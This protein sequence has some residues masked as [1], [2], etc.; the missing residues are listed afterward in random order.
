MA[1]GQG[2]FLSGKLSK[3]PVAESFILCAI[4]ADEIPII[5]LGGKRFMHYTISHILIL[6]LLL[7]S[8]PLPGNAQTKAVKPPQG[9]QFRLSEGSASKPDKPAPTIA[10]PLPQNETETLLSRLQPLKS[11]DDNEPEFAFRDRSLPPPQT[12]KVIAESFPN[13]IVADAPVASNVPLE[14]VRFAPEGEVPLAPHLSVTFSQPMVAVGSQAEAAQTVPVK[15]TPAVKGEWRWLGTKTILFAPENRFPMATDFTVE[16]PA[17]TKSVWGNALAATGEFRFSTPPPQV[18]TFAPQGD[19]IARN[20]LLFVAFDQRIDP[21]AVLKTLQLN[22]ANKRWKLR[23]ATTSEIEADAT[24]KPLTNSA[25]PG[26]W[27]AF[28]AINEALTTTRTATNVLPANTSFSVVIDAGTPSAEGPRTMPKAQTYSFRTYSTFRLQKRGCDSNDRPVNCDPY[29]GWNLE[30]SNPLDEESF[31]E[32]MIRVVPKVDNLQAEIYDNQL[33]LS[34]NFKPLTTYT[35]SLAPNLKDQFGQTLGVTAPLTFRV[36]KSDPNFSGPWSGLHTL[37]PFGPRAISYYSINHKSVHVAIYAVTPEQYS[38]FVEYDRKREDNKPATPPGTR[39]FSRLIQL[40][41]KP[42]EVIE[43]RIDLAR[44]LNKSY[45]H[46]VLVVTP[47]QRRNEYDDGEARLWVQSTNIGLDAFVDNTELVGWAT[48]LKDGKPVADAE[49]MLLDQAKYAKKATTNA[50]GLASIRLPLESVSDSPKILLVSKGEDMAILPEHNYNY[51]RDSNWHWKPVASELRWHVFDDRA[52]YRPG[53]EVHIKG[54]ARKLGKDK[55]GDVQVIFEGLSK[56]SY[57]VSDSRHNTITNGVVNVNLY[58]GFDVA[59][60][61]PDNANIGPASVQFK[62]LDNQIFVHQF[63]VQEFRRPE[64]EVTASAS[65]APHFVGSSADVSVSA[66]YYAGGGLADAA[67]NWHVT[68]TPTNFTPPNRDEFTFGK[69]EP[70]WNHSYNYEPPNLQTFASRT[71]ADGKHHLHMDFD[72]VSPARPQSVKAE[73]KVTDVNR[74]QWAASSTLLVHPAA[75]YVGLRAD[76]MFVQEG[77]PLTGQAIVTNLDGKAMAGRVIRLRAV[78]LSWTYKKGEWIEEEK[79]AQELTLQSSNDAV[80]F[81]FATKTG[82]SYR[83]IATIQDDKERRNESEI[84][85]WVAGGKLPPSKG[86]EQEKVEL[87]PNQKEFRAGDTAELLV[88][89]PFFPAEGVLTLRRSG[90]IETRRFTMP[91]AAHTLQIP[92]QEAWTPNIHAQ[93]DLVG[94]TTRE[95]DKGELDKS[96]PKRPAFASGAIELKIPPLQR[97]LNVQAIP[98]HKGLEPGGATTVELEVKDATGKALAKSEIALVV[99]DE[100][101]LALSDYKLRDPLATFYPARGDDVEAHHQREQLLLSDEHELRRN[102]IAAFTPPN[103]PPMSI[104]SGNKE[105]AAKGVPPQMSQV[106]QVMKAKEL[107]RGRAGIGGGA[108]TGGL[109]GIIDGGLIKAR[110][111]FNPLAV[112]AASVI[113]D[114]NGKASVNVTLPDSLTRYR[115]MA[116]ATDGAQR[117]GIGESAITARLPLMV[118]PAA[119][120]FLNFGDQVELPVVLQNQTDAPMIVDVALRATNAKLLEAAGQRIPIPANDRAEIRFPVTTDKPGTAQFQIAAATVINGRSYADAA[121]I[122]LPVWTPATTEA[123]ATYGEVD[124][125]A[126]VQPVKA[127]ANAFTQFGGLEITTSSTQ[128]QALTDAVLYLTSYPYECAE[129]VSSRVLAVAALR[130]VLSA[131]AANGLPAPEELQ[132]AVARDLQKLEGMQNPDGGFGFWKRG[133][134]SWPYLSIHVAHALQRAKEKGFAVPEKMIEQSHGYLLNLERHIPNDYPLEA[135]H[136]LTAYALYVLDLSGLRYPQRA[137]KLMDDA[138]LEQLSLE[139]VGW[140]LPVVA[141]NKDAG[142]KY[143]AAIRKHLN[144]RVEETAATAHFTTNYKDGAHLLLASNR[145]TDGILLEALINDQPNS[146]LIPKL[147][148]GLLANRKQGR[149]MNTQENAFILLALDQYFRTYE[150]VTPNFVARVWLGEACANEQTFAGRSTERHQLNVPMK[151]LTGASNLTLNKTGQGRLYFR[152]GMQYAPTDLQQKAADYGFTV[153]RSYEAIDDPNDVRRAADGTWRI[154]AGAQVRV[155]LTMVAPSRRYHVALVDALPAGLEALN[156]ALAVTGEIPKDEKEKPA[157]YW[158]WNRPWYE[159]QNLRD[160]RVEAFTSLLWEGVYNY[161]Y[162]A[163][164]TTPGKFIVPPAKAEE[165]YQPE[166]F[167]RSASD[168]VIVE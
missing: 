46:V 143:V 58:G 29:D 98:R 160:E 3:F 51:R 83:L 88:Q 129:Q 142:T 49:L 115:V 137:A 89:V 87:I 151:A 97:K 28:R 66:A 165:M 113:T 116:V 94:T 103:A 150:N 74:Q 73:A 79:D 67:V 135:R 48:S 157:R 41:A 13:N 40:H 70:W 32:Q 122:S 33:H 55:E 80:P 81:R 124:A 26:S 65:A 168:Q 64:Y 120:R 158:W 125:G 149:W 133:E 7:P 105:V 140:L 62:T 92:I 75:L 93:V 123:F 161:A 107:P 23:L 102:K 6:A 119:P 110:V 17:G 109:G 1:V 153:E 128:L 14:V 34:G 19:S 111:N 2:N 144:N 156:P 25:Q 57:T 164:A 22:G 118:R 86:V 101:I 37:D 136:T 30:F 35:V 21:A 38:Q 60:K 31:E 15:L 148:R 147:V 155:R 16:I 47:T 145:R 69:W 8:F 54:W 44:A 45:G 42:E 59:F 56:V 10:T 154:K 138:K 130:D 43:T 82:G 63:Q 162:V 12:G 90:L 159:H 18:K 36:G 96:L 141:R 84:Q 20:P 167:G 104:L 91:S 5:V 9:L 53:E 134:K 72:S 121:E 76:R 139:A 117:F 99:V 52:M 77:E 50:E 112:F 127:P 95:N 108:G 163:R 106:V 27:L 61:L 11:Q 68:A 131:F 24:I 166:T 4:T 152:I 39:V 78:L 146:D 132:A 71:G 85:M 100:A 114:A 126:M